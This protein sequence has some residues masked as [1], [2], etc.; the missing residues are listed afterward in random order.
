MITE[1]SHAHVNTLINYKTLYEE[2]H[3]D[4]ELFCKEHEEY[5]SKTSH[6]FKQLI[7]EIKK[8]I[9]V[10]YPKIEVS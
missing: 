5:A 10:K 1:T 6:L 4:I 8:T 3:R 2:L 9:K 7:E